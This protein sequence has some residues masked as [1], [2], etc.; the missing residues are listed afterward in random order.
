MKK[1]TRKETKTVLIGVEMTGK[2]FAEMLANYDTDVWE[3]LLFELPITDR[4]GE[5]VQFSVKDKIEIEGKVRIMFNEEEFKSIGL[6][7]L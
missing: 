5:A 4:E 2:E 1:L 7:T 6:P 3:D